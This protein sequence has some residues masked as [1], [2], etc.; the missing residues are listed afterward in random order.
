MHKGA[1]AMI[2]DFIKVTSN[3]WRG[4][5]P[6]V[7]ADMVQLAHIGIKKIIKLNS[8]QSSDEIAWCKSLGIQLDYIPLS[9]FWAPSDANMKVI[10]DSLFIS[11][12]SQIPTFVH[13]E[14]GEDR[15]GLVLGIVRVK[16]FGWTK[17]KAF[18]EMLANG[19]H[20]F[21]LGLLWYWWKK[22]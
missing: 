9:G 4:G 18:Q 2:N 7:Q 6:L 17:E 10:Q 11:G 19:F 14:H 16:I 12:I 3:L 8:D 20:P 15:T 5:Q 1:N 13:C 22:V 21:L